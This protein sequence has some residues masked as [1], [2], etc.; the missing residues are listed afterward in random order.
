GSW[1]QS[2]HGRRAVLAILAA[3]VVVAGAARLV[4]LADIPKGINPDE[5]D[6]ASWAI[7]LLTGEAPRNLFESGWWYISNVSYWLLAGVMKALGVGYA[8]ARALGAV[9][10]WLTFVA[11]VWIALRHFGLRVAVLTGILGALLGV[12]LQFARELTVATP[13]A[14]LWTLSVGFFL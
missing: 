12:S 3:L 13:T 10:G 2:I 7:S 6:Q 11:V 14:L 1:P 4:G 8:Q 9:S 5:G